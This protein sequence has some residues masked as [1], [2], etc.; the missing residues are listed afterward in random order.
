MQSQHKLD[1]NIFKRPSTFLIERYKVTN[2]QR[3]ANADMVGDLLAKKRKFSY[4]YDSIQASEL[5]KI[6][7]IIWE[8]NSLFYTLTYIESNVEKT[9]IVYTGAIPSELYRTGSNWV[10]KGVSFDL[11]EK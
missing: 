7:D 4:K 5:N 10:W 9:A 3:L 8:S 11:I 6:L 1:G 2:L